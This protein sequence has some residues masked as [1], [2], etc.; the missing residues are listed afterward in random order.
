MNI[1]RPI[2]DGSSL[3]RLL[4]SLPCPYGPGFEY[5][6]LSDDSHARFLW[7]LPITAT[8]EKFRHD[9]GL[10]AMESK[11]EEDGIDYLDPFR[12]SLC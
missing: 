3:D 4:V 9:F 10:E 1:G 11:F 2:V 8:E 7:L 12:T 6:H 5:G